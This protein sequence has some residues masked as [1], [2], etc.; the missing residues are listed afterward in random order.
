LNEQKGYEYLIDAWTIV[1]RRHPDWIL[2][3]YGSGEMYDDLLSRI[4]KNGITDSLIINDPTSDIVSKYLECSF[5]IMSSRFEGFPMVL[6]EAMS[7][8]LPCVSFDCPT[9]A[10]DIIEDEYNGY[11]VEYLKVENLA[12]RIC[13]MIEDVDLR[14]EMGK[15]S[16]ESVMSYL[17]EKIMKSWVS[18]FDVLVK[19]Q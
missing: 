8:G 12:D 6:L 14:K 5:Y 4:R 15:H 17:P 19:N 18:L 13:D 11:L 9:G 1:H 3:V 16:K 7:C 2:N 10:R